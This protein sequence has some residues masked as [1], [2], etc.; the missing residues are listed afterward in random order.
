MKMTVI[1]K[2][3]MGTCFMGEDPLLFEKEKEALRLGIE[4]GMNFIDTA[5]MYGEGLSEEFIGKAL[6]GIRRE[7]YIMTSKVYPHNAGRENIFRSCENSIKRLGC[8]YLDFYLLHWRGDIP[9]EETVWCMEELRRRGLI[10]EWGVSNFD[11]ADMD[12]LFAVDCGKNCAVD[13]VMYHIGTRG[14]EFDLLPWLREHNISPVAYCPLAQ[15]GRLRRMREIKDDPLLSEISSSY[16]I[17]VMQLV[18]A[19]VLRQNGM[20]AIPKASSADHVLLNRA[21]AD[22]KISPDDWRK[23]DEAYA[24]P[25]SKMFLDME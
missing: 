21:A 5:E 16:G 14:I 17:T 11:V 18:L 4:L 6:A 7:K 2:L 13:E 8:G 12:E 22:V 23:I 9:L 24:P 1:P 10:R 19:F 15:A 3:G 25:T 20:C